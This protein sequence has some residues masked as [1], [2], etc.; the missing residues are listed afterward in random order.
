[1]NQLNNLNCFFLGSVVISDLYLFQET[2][3]LTPNFI[4][5]KN[6]YIDKV[7]IGTKGLALVI[8]KLT[9]VM[10]LSSSNNIQYF[11]DHKSNTI[12]ELIKG[13]SRDLQKFTKIF[14]WN[15]DFC[16]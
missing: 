16:I 12:S 6:K 4:F 13:K 3:L 14:E 10:L 1:M 15:N 2:V 11:G 7:N 8:I 5:S 9:P